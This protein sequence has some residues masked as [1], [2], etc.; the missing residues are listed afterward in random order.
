MKYVSWILG[1]LGLGT[2]FA[3][4]YYVGKNRERNACEA[5][6][7]SVKE[8]YQK[9]VD[10]TKRKLQKVYGD[11]KPEDEEQKLT[12]NGDIDDLNARIV[13][14][15]DAIK[16]N[17]DDVIY[18]AADNVWYNETTEKTYNSQNVFVVPS[19]LFSFFGEG[20]H[21]EKQMAIATDAGEYFL[22]TYEPGSYVENILGYSASSGGKE[23]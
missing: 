5:D 12:E 7:A 18:F 22:L 9:R 19:D 23:E 21:K 16:H 10:E 1:L 4:G 3:A 20:E 14:Y 8:E 13:T 2:G 11:T 6:I 15:Q 17:P